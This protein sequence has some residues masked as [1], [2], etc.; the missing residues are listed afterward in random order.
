[1]NIRVAPSDAMLD[2][3][4][5]L[6]IGPESIKLIRERIRAARASVWNGPMGLFEM[7]AFA[8]GTR[9]IADAM[10]D[11]T[12][13]GAITIVGGGD[14]AAALAKFGMEGRMS[15]I[16]TGGGASLELLEG[17]ILPG[18]SALNR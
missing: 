2:G 11:A 7:D 17:K 10:A 18:V 8:G 4:R 14:S 12:V 1:M 6:D 9:A 15:H 5:G 3:Y 16:S 13:S